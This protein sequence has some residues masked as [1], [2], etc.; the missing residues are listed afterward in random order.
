V[1]VETLNIETDSLKVE[2]EKSPEPTQ[3][4]LSS[5]PTDLFQLYFN[6][7]STSFRR[8][9]EEKTEIISFLDWWTTAMKNFPEPIR[10]P[11]AF[12]RSIDPN[13]G[14]ERLVTQWLVWKQDQVPKKRLKRSHNDEWQK[15][16]GLSATMNSTQRTEDIISDPR[17]LMATRAAGGLYQIGMADR[18]HLQKLQAAFFCSLKEQD[19]GHED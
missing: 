5:P 19:A 16:L 15:V 2:G 14:Q 18:N 12:L 11:I 3:D 8:L 17:L 6:S 4:V 7:L 9:S 10:N 1:R 13:T